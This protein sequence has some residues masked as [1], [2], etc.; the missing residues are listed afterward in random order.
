MRLREATAVVWLAVRIILVK[1]RYPGVSVIDL[2][3]PT[4]RYKSG[5]DSASAH[6][7]LLDNQGVG[8]R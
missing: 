2:H 5:F 1:A 6:R 7:R 4:Y 3:K 8:V